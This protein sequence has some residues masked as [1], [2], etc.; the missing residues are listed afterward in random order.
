VGP[1]W[2]DWA[3]FFDHIS[4]ELSAAIPASCGLSDGENSDMHRWPNRYI[5]ICISI[6][7]DRAQ[8]FFD[9]PNHRR[10][11]VR[12]GPAAICR[13]EIAPGRASDMRSTRS[14]LAD[15][16]LF[17]ATMSI[18]DLGIRT[19]HKNCRLGAFERIP[20]ILPRYNLAPVTF[21]GSLSPSAHKTQS[22]SKVEGRFLPPLRLASVGAKRRPVLQGHHPQKPGFSGVP[23]RRLVQNSTIFARKELGPLFR[24]AQKALSKIIG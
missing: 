5:D 7:Y 22:R 16:T 13:R 21:G 20:R 12:T 17:F 6:D 10:P 9:N 14:S 4:H 3:N 19:A 2:L 1:Y 24:S 15:S 8:S 11:T 23:T 18:F